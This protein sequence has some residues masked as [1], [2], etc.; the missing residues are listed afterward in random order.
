[1]TLFMVCRHHVD[2]SYASVL[3]LH[4]NYNRSWAKTKSSGA[5]KGGTESLSVRSK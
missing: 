3:I 2:L 4:A 1:M 5:Q